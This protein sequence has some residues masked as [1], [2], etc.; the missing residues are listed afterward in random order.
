MKAPRAIPTP[1]L[2]FLRPTHAS[3]A[4][5][6]FSEGSA[7]DVDEVDGLIAC[8]DCPLGKIL[9]LTASDMMATTVLTTAR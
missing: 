2:K 7:A 8:S 6:R 4:A 3:I 1:L 5:S 9:R